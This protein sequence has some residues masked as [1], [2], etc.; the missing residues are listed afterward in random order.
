MHCSLCYFFTG[1]SGNL[2]R[3]KNSEIHKQLV[4]D[5]FYPQATSRMAPGMVVGRYVYATWFGV[6][7]IN[8][9]KVRVI[10]MIGFSRQ[11]KCLFLSVD[12]QKAD[13]GWED[14]RILFQTGLFRGGASQVV[15]NGH[16]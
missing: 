8:K 15:N 11:H 5:S 2:P 9:A 1:N 14:F 7:A 13:G 16:C 6:E 10:I 3:F 12:K 4:Q